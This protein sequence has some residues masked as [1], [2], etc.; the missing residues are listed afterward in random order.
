[1]KT[2]IVLAALAITGIFLFSETA[3][4]WD[5]LITNDTSYIKESGSVTI[6]GQ[7]MWRTASKFYD[8]DTKAQDLAKDMTYLS[9]PLRGKYCINDFVQT[10]AIVQIISTDDGDKNYS[11]LGDIW[12][13]AKWAVRPDGLITIR[14]ALDLPIG[15]D[16]KGLGKPGGYGLDA[17]F[18]TGIKNGPIDLNG[19]FGLR[20][21]A[22][23]ADTNIEPGTCVYLAGKAGYNLTEQLI[24]H[25]AMEFMNWSDRKVDKIVQKNSGIN[26]LE[27]RIGPD[28]KFNETIFL[29]LDLTYDIMGKN[30]PL[31]KGVIF[32]VDYGY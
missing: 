28:Y 29:R 13:G 26:W 22:E 11:G 30:T 20:Y 1:M 24:G 5:E 17:G 4:A 27:L 8:K 3:M 19:Q 10:F 21:N 23:S 18:M 2:I 25:F 9:I 32:C 16:K 7:G 15:Y 6:N 31:S 12:L 14:G